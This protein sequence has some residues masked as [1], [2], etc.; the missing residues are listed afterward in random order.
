MQRFYLPRNLSKIGLFYCGL[1]L[2]ACLTFAL[3]HKPTD[4]ALVVSDI[5]AV[6]MEVPAIVAQVQQRA[7]Q[8]IQSQQ[9]VE[10]TPILE[11]VVRPG[12]TLM[13]MLTTQGISQAEATAL[14]QAVKKHHDPRQLAIGQRLTLTFDRPWVQ[15]EKVLQSMKLP[16]GPI[17]HLELKRAGDQQFISAMIEV[18]VRH[19][20]V[21]R[22]GQIQSTLA[23]STAALGVPLSVI[24]EIT[25]AFSYDVD[26]QRDIHIGDKFDILY[27]RIVSEDGRYTKHGDVLYAA[28]ELQGKTY[29]IYRHTTADGATGFYTQDGRNNRKTFLRTPVNAGRI[30]SGYGM[31]HHPTQGFTKMH[32]GVDFAAPVG[33]PILAASNGV[34]TKVGRN[35]GYGNM[36]EIRH[37][38]Q[39][40]TLYGHASRF[41]A[42]IQKGTRV[43]QGQVIAYV[44]STGRSTGPH[45]HYEIRIDGRPVNPAKVKQTQGTMLSGKELARFKGQTQSLHALLDKSPVQAELAL[46]VPVQSTATTKN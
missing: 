43:K 10:E 7:P 26:F 32:Q 21:R 27:E 9:I 40:S 44:G 33:T 3:Q 13:S 35:G 39:Y 11:I 36:V 29:A 46:S 18:P 34:V 25:R 1:A 37:D 2:L 6:D 38:A 5:E 31:R 20:A 12:D 4:D 28:L 24:S 19:H 16:C 30:S 45:L 15:A 22:S 42:G 14:I 17:R 8:Q 23:G 41:A